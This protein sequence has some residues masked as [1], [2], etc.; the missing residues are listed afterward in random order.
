MKISLSILPIV[1]IGCIGQNQIV[2]SSTDTENHRHSI[3]QTHS[4]GDQNYHAVM[5]Y[6][7][8]EGVLAIYFTKTNENSAT[9]LSAMNVKALLTLPDGKTKEFYFQKP[10][11]ETD[12]TGS[13]KAQNK[14][15]IKPSS[16]T[17]YIK[18]EFLKNLSAFELEV[19][20]P[21]KGTTYVLKYEY[22]EPRD[23]YIPDAF[24]ILVDL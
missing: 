3:T 22:S 11:K 9:I 7:D 8:R 13:Q 24:F 16:E 1:L 23:F 17:I 20:L 15:G 6:D 18:R 4:F 14:L 5:K 10:E 19:W 2:S 21:V 12:V